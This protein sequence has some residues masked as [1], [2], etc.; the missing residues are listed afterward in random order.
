MQRETVSPRNGLTGPQATLLGMSASRG[1]FV[2]TLA[3][4][5]RALLAV[6]AR[7]YLW[8]VAVRQ[9]ARIARPRWWKRPPFL[10]VPDAGYLRFRL[11]TAYGDTVAPRPDDLVSYLEWCRSR[12]P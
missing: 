5:V 9:A 7:P 1:S 2:R 6:V 12:Q 11:E 10:P 8:P 4:W 3:G